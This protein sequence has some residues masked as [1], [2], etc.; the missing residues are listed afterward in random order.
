MKN[1]ELELADAGRFTRQIGRFR[2]TLKFLQ[3]AA[4]EI[5]GANLLFASLLSIAA[6]L[7]VARIAP[8]IDRDANW[9]VAGELV[10]RLP[11]LSEIISSEKPPSV[12]SDLAL[13]NPEVEVFLLNSTGEVVYPQNASSSPS[14]SFRTEIE[15][16][17]GE[18][19]SRF[20][21][22]GRDPR[23]SDTRVPY[24]ALPLRK[25]FPVGTEEDYLYVVIRSRVSQYLSTLS[26]G[27]H[28]F[29]LY[30]LRLLPWFLGI[31]LLC[32]LF[33]LSVSRS[34][35]RMLTLVEHY[36]RGDLNKRWVSTREDDVNRLG[37][38]IDTFARQAIRSEETARAL[39]KQRCSFLLDL[40]HDLRG[41]LSAVRVGID[42]LSQDKL[43]ADSP[44]FPVTLSA[45][46]ASTS[47]LRNLAAELGQRESAS[48]CLLRVLNAEKADIRDLVGSLFQ[49]AKL[50]A[51]EKDL[52]LFLNVPDA[53]VLVEFDS[54]VIERV[55]LNLLENALRYTPPGGTITLE[56]ECHPEN[57]TIAVVDS[58]PGISEE[59]RQKI[60]L[61]YVRGEKQEKGEGAG[62]GLATVK[63]LL[64]RH[65]SQIELQSSLGHGSR[66]SFSLS[67]ELK[68]PTE[69]SIPRKDQRPAQPNA[70]THITPFLQATFFGLL[71][72]LF[73]PHRVSVL[74]I[75]TFTASA[76]WFGSTLASPRKTAFKVLAILLLLGSTA[77]W[78][79]GTN[80]PYLILAPLLFASLL[81]VRFRTLLSSE[82][83][84]RFFQQ[85]LFAAVVVNAL[86]LGWAG[87]M[88]HLTAEDE[89]GRHSKGHEQDYFR[90]LI[91]RAGRHWCEE[92]MSFDAAE[93]SFSDF[94][95]LNL[96]QDLHLL[97]VGGK[98]ILGSSIIQ[99]RF[100]DG[101][102]LGKFDLHRAK[103]GYFERML[104]H[105]RQPVIL[106]SVLPSCS[107]FTELFVVFRSGLLKSLLQQSL[108][109]ADL[110]FFLFG[111]L[112][113]IP[114][115]FFLSRR[116]LSRCDRIV[117]E[118]NRFVTQVSTNPL[119]PAP[120]SKDALVN[121]IVAAVSSILQTRRRS[122]EEAEASEREI[123]TLAQFAGSEYESL[124]TFLVQQVAHLSAFSTPQGSPKEL[125][126]SIRKIQGVLDS[127]VL[128]TQA[129]F[130]LGQ[131]LNQL[132]KNA[133]E[134]VNAGELIDD[135]IAEL[136]GFA[137]QY[138]IVLR[139][140]DSEEIEFQ[141]D[142]KLL[143]LALAS[144]LHSCIRAAER[145]SVVS[146]RVERVSGS[147]EMEIHLQRC[148]SGAQLLGLLLS[149]EL[150]EIAGV[151]GE[152]LE[153][154]GALSGYRIT[155]P[156]SAESSSA[157]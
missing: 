20:A 63:R 17:T 127:E 25:S 31:F 70:F 15:A 102:I 97:G 126:T 115:S 141:G 6:T 91:D 88:L 133:N 9:T 46:N 81:G 13:A 35:R 138:E 86:G 39:R 30:F 120:T 57:V 145:G 29:G 38:R 76:L 99:S 43:G 129:L 78:M 150:L 98:I 66:F 149:Q 21:L 107:R 154:N 83:G 14:P 117:E 26:G 157:S 143:S 58:G 59:D 22:L 108:H 47:S 23:K 136:L 125:S 131:R 62:V 37:E 90:K 7:V 8:R 27:A 16:Q 73:T 128:L 142:R 60:F 110:L 5:L 4:A 68:R 18:D 103:Q 69:T 36:A 135:T 52:T 3:H 144:A 2:L 77:F 79:F 45:M 56:L 95:A 48:E 82:K 156:L 153:T 100:F 55:L 119:E 49:Q 104:F 34:F 72:P 28:F 40:A 155:L 24:I 147:L 10:R 32:F 51:A 113:A 74:S 64:T 106:G 85:T 12:L 122:Q 94:R 151:L 101:V 61:P 111:I 84:G 152:P 140:A 132:P 11:P 96:K 1:E 148:D 134:T 146:V 121:S 71:L 109:S 19:T 123:H 130:E 118:T 93:Q 41:P 89:M 44:S 124:A 80:R 53:P 67:R 75:A 42:T 139:S 137:V 114:F 92:T 33:S 105:P 65:Q 54:H 50:R 112:I 87:Y 116:S